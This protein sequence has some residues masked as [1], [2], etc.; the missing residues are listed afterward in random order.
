MDL[1][2]IVIDDTELDHFIAKKMIYHADKRFEVIPFYE[3]LSALN[4]ITSE[5]A[6]TKNGAN[7]MVLLDIYMP[8]MDGYAFLDAFE[9][10][11]PAIQAKY[12]IV[13]LTSSHQP[14]DMNEMSTYKSVK[15]FLSKPLLAEDLSSVITRMI[16]TRGMEM[17]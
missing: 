4:Y 5:E 3:A 9:A 1:S 17:L 11:D 7:T 15:G 13:A 8:I 14:T 2:F 12:Y 16:T 10:L 6:L